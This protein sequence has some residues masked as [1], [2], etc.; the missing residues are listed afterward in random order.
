[1]QSNKFSQRVSFD[2][3]A[4]DKRHTTSITLRFAWQFSTYGSRKIIK[5]VLKHSVGTPCLASRLHF[6]HHLFDSFLNGMKFTS[7]IPRSR[8]FAII[9]SWFNYRSDE[10]HSCIR[11]WF[12]LLIVNICWLGWLSRQ[13][14]F[15]FSFTSSLLLLFFFFCR[16]SCFVIRILSLEPDSFLPYFFVLK[17]GS[18]LALIRPWLVSTRFHRYSKHAL[19]NFSAL[20][21]HIK[22]T[23]IQSNEFR[24]R[25][26]WCQMT[27]ESYFF[28]VSLFPSS[29][30]W[31]FPPSSRLER[32]LRKL[33]RSKGNRMFH[34]MNISCLFAMTGTI[35]EVF[36]S[37]FFM[38]VDGLSDESSITG[39]RKAWMYFFVCAL[40]SSFYI[41]P[42]L[43]LTRNRKSTEWKECLVN[44]PTADDCSERHERNEREREEGGGEEGRGGGGGG[45]GDVCPGHVAFFQLVRRHRR[46]RR[47]LHVPT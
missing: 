2:D 33:N 27:R 7:N 3:I 21:V 15:F 29:F 36:L 34:S 28:S 35:A 39:Y 42:P 12:I 25:R 46:F 16:F 17:S 30:S 8:R 23:F 4:S 10:Y 20:P 32:L 31:I 1:M 19:D 47:T 13:F 26:E 11:P 9:E 18:L 45:L 14:F 38:R 5:H 41:I 6:T 24:S 43:F 22:W 40:P 44:W 37:F